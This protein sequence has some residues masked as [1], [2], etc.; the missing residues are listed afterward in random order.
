MVCDVGR[1]QEFIHATG[2]ASNAD[3]A[4]LGEPHI[5]RGCL[6]QHRVESRP[7]L[8]KPGE[9]NRTSRM[10]DEPSRVPCGPTGHDIAL[11]QEHIA[12]AGIG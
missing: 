7:V 8:G 5:N 1:V 2:C 11:D 3:G 6:L 4:G 9:G 10:C 12:D